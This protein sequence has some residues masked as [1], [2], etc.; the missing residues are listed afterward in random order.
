M[1]FLSGGQSLSKKRHGSTIVI[2]YSAQKESSRRQKQPCGL[3]LP[4]AGAGPDSPCDNSYPELVHKGLIMIFIVTHIVGASHVRNTIP[5]GTHVSLDSR[6]PSRAFEAHFH[7][8]NVQ[9]AMISSGAL[10]PSRTTHQGKS[11]LVSALNPTVQLLSI[12]QVEKT[13]QGCREV[14]PFEQVLIP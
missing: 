3:I 11:N 12:P 1:T 10:S 4:W 13:P 14:A 5:I 8:G 6:V 7:E 2:D 9:F